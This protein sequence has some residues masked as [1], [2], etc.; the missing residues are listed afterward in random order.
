VF[1]ARSTPIIR[2]LSKRVDA[3]AFIFVSVRAIILTCRPTCY[4]LYSAVQYT[5]QEEAFTATA[6]RRS[7]RL[8][9]SIQCHTCDVYAGI[10]TT[11]S[12][13][14]CVCA[15]HVRVAQNHAFEYSL[16]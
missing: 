5:M 16:G 1:V 12:S 9:H 11:T 10:P 13:H 7:V 8:L 14:T 15:N 3:S 2:F 6:C 4:R